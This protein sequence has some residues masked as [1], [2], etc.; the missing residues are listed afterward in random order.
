[1][2]PTLRSSPRPLSRP[3]ARHAGL[4]RALSCH[5]VCAAPCPCNQSEGEVAAVVRGRAHG[6]E[7]LRSRGKGVNGRVSG[8]GRGGA[9]RMN[10][11]NVPRERRRPRPRPGA[12]GNAARARDPWLRATAARRLGG[13][14]RPSGARGG[15]A[16]V[17][18]AGAARCLSEARRHCWEP[19]ATTTAAVTDTGPGVSTGDAGPRGTGSAGLVRW[20]GRVTSREGGPRRGGG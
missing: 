5:Y 17:E 3:S 10:E 13:E 18:R 12:N 14:R 19:A 2:F 6:L 20:E 7:P 9:S 8:G 1:M 15:G 16:G 11:K 4:T